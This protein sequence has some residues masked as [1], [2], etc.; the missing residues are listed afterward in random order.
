LQE[1][2]EDIKMFYENGIIIDGAYLVIQEDYITINVIKDGLEDG[3]QYSEMM[4]K[5]LNSL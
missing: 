3:R 5:D 2:K 4:K 1:L